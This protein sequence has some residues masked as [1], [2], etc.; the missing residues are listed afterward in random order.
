[1]FTFQAKGYAEKL[2]ITDFKASDGW[3]AKLKRKHNLSFKIL[4]GESA[5]VDMEAVNEWYQQLPN[6]LTN[7]EPEYIFNLDETGLFLSVL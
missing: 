1:M 7:Y 4:S 3:L 5:D 2:G 6:I